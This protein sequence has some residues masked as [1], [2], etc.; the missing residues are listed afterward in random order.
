[1]ER[2]GTFAEYFGTFPVGSGRESANSA[3][4]GVTYLLGPSLQLD[5]RV[6]LGLDGPRPN[7]FLGTGASWRW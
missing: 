3:D 7:Y 4:V 1:T 5:M 6:G 2:L